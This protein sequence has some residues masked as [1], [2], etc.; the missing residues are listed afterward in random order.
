[1]GVS[2]K[3]TAAVWS[4]Y[5]HQCAAS[6][7]GQAPPSGHL[8]RNS[9]FLIHAFMILH[10]RARARTHAH[11]KRATLLTGSSSTV[12]LT[13]NP[14]TRFGDLTYGKTA[15]LLQY[16]R[17]LKTDRQ[18][19]RLAQVLAIS[20]TQIHTHINTTVA[21]ATPRTDTHAV[22][23]TLVPDG[24]GRKERQHGILN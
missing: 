14:S 19:H 21:R 17:Y 15:V 24:P 2:V 6:E 22:R 8:A 10:A 4:V 7:P 1:M 11:T 5:Y 13:Q 12:P 9:Q 20:R 16:P 18:T 3:R 23:Y